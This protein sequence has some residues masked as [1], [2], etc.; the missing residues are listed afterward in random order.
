MRG[1]LR[2]LGIILG[3]LVVAAVVVGVV[4]WLNWKRGNE[5]SDQAQDAYR[6]GN[7]SE[8]LTSYQELLTVFGLS[9]REESR[10]RDRIDEL[11]DYLK[12]ANLHENA[13]VDQAIAAYETFMDEHC[14]EW[15]SD[16]LYCTW[17]LTAIPAVMMDWAHTLEKLD[18]YQEFEDRCESVLEDHPDI[19]DDQ[20][21]KATM[22]QIYSDWADLLRQD[23]SYSAAIE[24]YMIVLSKYADTP[25]EEL[26]RRT[27]EETRAEHIIWLEENPAV[28]MAE[29]PEEVSRD[30]EG[31]WSWTTV[32]KETGGKVGYTVSG[33][34]WIEDAEGGRY[35]PWGTT[36]DRGSV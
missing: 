7:P 21:A 23:E 18:D 2:K 14:P 30:S 26:A 9:D 36:L 15:K 28:P 10:A 22:A 12:A 16:N 11:Q 27:L 32:F 3:V 33:S 20:Q 5:L 6:D 35:G 31:L 25:A 1:C 4:F 8:A 24:K 34:G 19:F 29:F 13:Q 17:T